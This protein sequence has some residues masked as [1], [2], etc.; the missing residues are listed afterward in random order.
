MPYR[1]LFSALVTLGLSLA[2]IL[3]SLGAVSRSAGAPKQAETP[4]EI[5]LKGA[6]LGGVKFTH[7]LHAEGHAAKKCETCHHASKPAKPNTEP[8]QACRDCHTKPTQAGMKVG[9]QAAFHA[10]TGKTG[11]CIDCHVKESAAG[12]KAPTKCVDCHKKT[13]V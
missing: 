1:R 2:V 3:I 12:K 10:P 8:Q 6:P 11:T 4:D 7:K 13:N 9:L 5:L